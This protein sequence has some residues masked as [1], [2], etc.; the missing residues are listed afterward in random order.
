MSM[1]R[2]RFFSVNSFSAGCTITSTIS[3]PP[4]KLYILHDTQVVPPQDVVDVYT[5]SSIART[6]DD[7]LA[8]LV[9]A[10]APNNNAGG[11]DEV[12]Y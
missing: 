2:P 11:D 8:A 9:A 6:Q 7:V 4:S 12:H 5:T 10:F 3:Y 1:R